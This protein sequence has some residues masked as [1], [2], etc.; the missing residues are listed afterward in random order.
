MK[1]K[2]L[3]IFIAILLAIPCYAELVDE[4]VEDVPQTQTEN[5]LPDNKVEQTLPPTEL[6]KSS[7]YKQPVSKKKIAK[8]FILA[9]S[10][11]AISSIV[12]FLLL[13]LY[14]KF[15]NEFVAQV[16]SVNGEIPLQ[17]PDD[18]EGAIRTFLEKTKWD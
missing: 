3:T 11:V 2:I 4:Y 15:R 10:G 5:L 6:P 7:A 12:I 14:N 16:K 18:M 1:N 9:M 8:K 13:T 17:S